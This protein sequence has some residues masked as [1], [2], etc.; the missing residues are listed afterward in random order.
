MKEKKPLGN[1]F[2]EISKNLA[3]PGHDDLLTDRRN[4]NIATREV[5][6]TLFYKQLRS[7]YK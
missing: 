6:Y 5:T 1:Q 4:V 7:G 3:E 2:R